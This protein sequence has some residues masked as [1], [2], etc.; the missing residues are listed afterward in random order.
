MKS[1]QSSYQYRLLVEITEASQYPLEDECRAPV[2]NKVFQN[3]ANQN[4]GIKRRDIHSMS[5]QEEYLIINDQM[6][7]ILLSFQLKLSRFKYP[8]KFRY[9]QLQAN[10]PDKVDS[11]LINS[12]LE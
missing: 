5:L 4:G 9:F 2:Q 11:C 6:G 10:F 3:I 1:V 8:F 7:N 12:E